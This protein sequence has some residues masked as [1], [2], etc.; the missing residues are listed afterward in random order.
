M[1]AKYTIIP[2]ICSMLLVGCNQRGVESISLNETNITLEEENTFSLNATTNLGPA[3]QDSL[4]WKTSDNFI[5]TVNS[6]GLVTANNEGQA[7]ITVYSK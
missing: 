2:L 4:N 1:K 6:N 5:A 3:D 7:T